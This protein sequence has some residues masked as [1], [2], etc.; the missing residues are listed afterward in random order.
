MSLV[1]LVC[2]I[3]PSLSTNV[4]PSLPFDENFGFSVV[5]FLFKCLGIASYIFSFSFS[6]SLSFVPYLLLLIRFADRF[7]DRNTS[8]CS[9][10]DF[11]TKLIFFK[12]NHVNMNVRL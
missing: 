7:N 2:I 1:T 12:L 5:M 10:G 6:L 9:G 8:L 11:V 4:I 3:P